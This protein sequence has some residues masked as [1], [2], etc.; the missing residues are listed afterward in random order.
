MTSSNAGELGA[1]PQELTVPAA[2]VGKRLDVFLAER[3]P[4]HS[5]MNL[6]RA[7]HAGGARVDGREVR[8]AFKLRIGQRVTVWLPELPQ[9]GPIPEDIPLDIL[10]EDEHFAVINKPRAMVV[11]PG[12]GHWK[13][14]LTAALAHHFQ[15]LSNVGGAVRPGVVHRLDRDTTGVIVI[16][17]TNRA[18]FALAQ[19]FEERVTEKEYLAIV[20]GVPDHDRDVIDLPIGVHQYQREKMAIRANHATSKPA[21]TFYEVVERFVGYALVRVLPKTGRTHQIRVHLSHLGY[22]VLCDRQYG[23]RS[24]IT[25]GELHRDPADDTILLDRHALHAHRLTIAHPVT[26]E[27]MTFHAPLPS[28]M[29]VM[30]D[31]LREYRSR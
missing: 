8:S 13:G 26:N 24:Q 29:Q 3:F 27:R 28:D 5:R 15:S 14:T 25:R 20:V 21:R 12:R 17:K 18:H 31:A 9:E 1:E 11:H 22:P 30:L 4:Y 10:F 16:A 6:R 19:Q 2:D 7:I 23:G